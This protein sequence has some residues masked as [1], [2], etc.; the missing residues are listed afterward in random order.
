MVL[1]NFNKAYKFVKVLPGPKKHAT[2]AALA[3]ARGEIKRGPGK[4]NI[5][6]IE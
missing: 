5:V 3:A 2:M 1:I 4:K 6:A